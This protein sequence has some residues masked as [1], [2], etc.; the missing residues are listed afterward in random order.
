MGELTATRTELRRTADALIAD[1]SGLFKWT[2][3]SLITLNGGA[4]LGLAN[5]SD[6]IGAGI[7][8]NSIFAFFCGCFFAVIGAIFAALS[9]MLYG[10]LLL[11]NLATGEPRK[12][13]E[14]K[15]ETSLRRAALCATL[16]AFSSIGSL[17]AFMVGGGILAA[18]LS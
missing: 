18:A 11:P 7:V 14:S 10:V 2:L 17:V 12:I 4:I 1:A 6:K 16:G 8:A 5:V 3:A 15:A 9:F 13:D